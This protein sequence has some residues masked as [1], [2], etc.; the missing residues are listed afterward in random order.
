M[1]KTADRG[2]RDDQDGGNP[3][4]A[5]L[6]VTSWA[7]MPRPTTGTVSPRYGG[8]EQPGQHLGPVAVWGDLQFPARSRARPNSRSE[9]RVV[10]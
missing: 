7:A 9:V 2:H 6:L 4:I 5:A 3:R 10:L 8:D 1:T